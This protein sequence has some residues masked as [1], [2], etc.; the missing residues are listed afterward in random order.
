MVGRLAD[1]VAIVTGGGTGI[2]AGIAE[3]LAHDGARVVISGRRRHLLQETVDRVSSNGGMIASVAGDTATEDG[4]K[5]LFRETESIFGPVEILVNNAAIAGPVA[6]IWETDT[7]GWEETL[8]IN[9]TGPWLCCREACR[10]M[11]ERRS[12]KIVNIGSIS[13]KRPLA[14][15]TPYTTTKMGLVGLT[16]TLAAE[17]GPYNI[18]VNL[19]SPG[20]VDTPRMDELAERW[21]TTRDALLGGI[22]E[23]SALKRVSQ[24][25][26]IAN[27]TAFLVSDE[28][29]NIQGI[30]I[31][32]DAGVWF[33]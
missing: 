4:V 1:R 6:P 14:T 9:L 5:A 17:V 18:N 16:R 23:T 24:P 7:P 19:I 30:D 15:R 26:D 27:L 12:G 32:V 21:N 22:A 25:Y 3:R 13:G 10:S 33:S 29:R 8:R 2:G 20:A 11:M 28:A 31:T